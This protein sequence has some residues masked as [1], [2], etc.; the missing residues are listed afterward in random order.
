MNGLVPQPEDP[1]DPLFP[2]WTRRNDLVLSW[3]TNCLSQDIFASVIYMNSTKEVWDVLSERYSQSDGPHVFHLKQAISSL[4]QDQ[5]DLSA[6]YT[7]LKGFW[8]EFL[9]YKPITNCSCGANCMCGL[10]KTL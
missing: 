6:Y 9:H 7:R 3:I 10:T 4:K 5:L 1:T 2:V 8:D